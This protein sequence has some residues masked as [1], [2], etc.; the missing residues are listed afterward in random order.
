MAF[1]QLVVN[2]HPLC[3]HQKYQAVR[4]FEAL[5]HQR[6][7][8]LDMTLPSMHL[9]QL[10]APITE[11]EKR[12]LEVRCASYSLSEVNTLPLCIHQIYKA[13]KH[14]EVP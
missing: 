5:G 10:D 4:H 12:H 3:I 7:T 6:L 11:A 9:L 13:V 2:T 8:A 14:L 1:V